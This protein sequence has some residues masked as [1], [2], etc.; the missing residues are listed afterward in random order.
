MKKI[1]EKDNM[2]IRKATP[3]DAED[4]LDFLAV[5]G[6]ESDNLSFGSEG[7]SIT[8]EKEREILKNI[9]ED[10]S[11]LFLVAI[12]DGKLIS[13]GIVASQKKKRFSHNSE[14]SISVLKEFWNRGVG[15]AVMEEMISFIRSLGGKRT[16]S[17]T[18]R[19][20]NHPAVHLYESL[21]FETTGILKDYFCIDN[22]YFDAII[23]NIH[24]N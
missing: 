18:V 1:F 16:I 9:G 24:I 6:G 4:I 12:Y 10:E 21:G 22:R 19:R 23:M 5:I 7:L 3:E 20:D 15:R 13:V 11:S 14:I 8:P 2:V 17:L